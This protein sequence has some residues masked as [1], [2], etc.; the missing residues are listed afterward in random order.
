LLRGV[1]RP[2]EEASH[3]ERIPEDPDR[4]AFNDGELDRLSRDDRDLPS[5]DRDL[6]R[7]PPFSGKLALFAIAVALLPGAASG[8][9]NAGTHQASNP[10]PGQTAQREPTSP[11]APAGTRDL[12]PR[13]N[14]Q[15]GITTAAA[16][17]KT[18]PLSTAPS[19]MDK[20]SAEGPRQ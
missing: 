14:T 9:N 20:S 12:T 8:L 13:A 3:D 17:L 10:P 7:A 19:T 1:I 6:D 5:L 18:T 16:P 15:P 2:T 4:P 11:Q